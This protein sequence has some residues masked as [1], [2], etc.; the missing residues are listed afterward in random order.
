MEINYEKRKNTELF[1][2]FKQKKFTFLSNVQNYLPIYKKFFLLNETNYNSVN[3]NHE[4][5]L[6]DI[7]NVNFDFKHLY[8]CALQNVKTEDIKEKDVFFKMA[9]LLDPFKYIVGKY[10]LTDTTLFNL[11]VHDSATEQKLVHPK[12]VDENN[13]A[14]VDGMFSFLSSTLIHKHNFYLTGKMD[15]HA[16]QI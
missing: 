5:F 10:D 11:P 12:I 4:W 6:K 15:F 9:P 13:S 8:S 16:Q 2:T 1:Q 7:K 14:Y 3:L